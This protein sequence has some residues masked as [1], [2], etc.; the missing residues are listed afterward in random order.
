MTAMTALVSGSRTL[1]LHQKVVTFLRTRAVLTRA[2]KTKYHRQND[3]NNN[4]RKWEVHSP[5]N[6]K[7]GLW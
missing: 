5:E 2:D 7:F 1:W 6:I 3:L 4:F